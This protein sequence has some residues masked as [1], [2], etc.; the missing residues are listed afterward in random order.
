MVYFPRRGPRTSTQ[1]R[2]ANPREGVDYAGP[3]KVI[4]AQLVE[5]TTAPLPATG[6]G[7]GESHE[8]RCEDHEGGE[9]H[10]FGY[11]VR[12]DGGRGCSKHG[13]KDKVGPSGLTE[14]GAAVGKMS[15]VAGRACD[16]RSE[17]KDVGDAPV[18]GI[19][20]VESPHR[21]EQDAGT[22]DEDVLEEKVD[23]VLLL[24]ES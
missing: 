20:R 9:L 5:E 4:E 19:H 13:L 18:T 3:G 17:R 2:V 14:S 11:R 23:A 16:R 10:A 24:R 22:D 7:I 15:V 6:N 1:A 21:V 8:E 12:N